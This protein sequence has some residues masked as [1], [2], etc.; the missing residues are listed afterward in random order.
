MLSKNIF[1]KLLP[2]KQHFQ[3][4]S[5]KKDVFKITFLKNINLMAL[6]YSSSES[7]DSSSEKK[8]L[9]LSLICQITFF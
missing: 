8:S 4:Y 5:L 9:K 3:N 1:S 7:S 2:Q 6:I